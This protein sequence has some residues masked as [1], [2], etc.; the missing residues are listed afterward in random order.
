MFRIFII[1]FLL[2][3]SFWARAQNSIEIMV[4]DI[5]PAEGHLR[6]ALYIESDEFLAS[7]GM[8]KNKIVKVTGNSMKVTFDNIPNGT[9]SVSL[10]HD[11]NSND[12]FDFNFIGMPLETYGFSNNVFHRF[13]APNFE[14]C[15]FYTE[16]DVAMS[17]NLR[18]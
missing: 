15:A 18:R 13:W 16:E 9:Y 17:I 7:E 11:K 5:F 12:T 3:F 10:Y 2:F 1:L 6:L 4:H 8:F 14:E